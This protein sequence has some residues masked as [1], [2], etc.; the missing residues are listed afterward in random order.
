MSQLPAEIADRRHESELLQLRRMELVRQVV[1]GRRQV[2]DLGQQLLYPCAELARCLRGLLAEEIHP[3][4]QERQA[5]AQVVVQLARDPPGFVLPGLEQSA[6]EYPQLHL[7][8]AEPV[9]CLL[10]QTDI[11]DRRQD[12]RPGAG[13]GRAQRD[14]HRELASVFA[15]PEELPAFPH[16]TDLG[17]GGKSLPMSS[18]LRPKAIRH[19]HLHGLPSLTGTPMTSA[20]SLCFCASCSSTS[21]NTM[22]TP[23]KI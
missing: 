17:R 2:F 16:E 22:G 7:A 18:V 8:P 19:Q 12:E 4:G 6:G 3:D 10:A 13:L 20:G 23:G 1:H 15:P 5:L 14:L 11:R 21:M 9:F